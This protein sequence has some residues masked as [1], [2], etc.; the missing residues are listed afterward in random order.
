MLWGITFIYKQNVGFKCQIA[1]FS[2]TLSFGW[3]ETTRFLHP[4]INSIFWRLLDWMENGKQKA[5]LEK[6]YHQKTWPQPPVVWAPRSTLCLKLVNSYVRLPYWNYLLYNG[7]GWGWGIF[8]S[9][10]SRW[11]CVGWTLVAGQIDLDHF[12]Q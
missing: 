4:F 6:Q 9:C 2:S 11:W 1:T 8:I 10:S 5:L 3:A 7:T 12:D